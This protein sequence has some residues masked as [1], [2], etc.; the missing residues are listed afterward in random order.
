MP[1]TSSAFTARREGRPW[2]GL[3]A[4]TAKEVADH[5]G[6]ARMR[7]LAGLILLTA[8]GATGIAIRTLKQTESQDPFLFL[9]LLTSSQDPLPSFL[10]F[11]SFFVPIAAIALGFDAINSEVSRRTLPRLVAQPI[12]RDAV[13]LGK[14]LAGMLTLTLT[15]LALWL[16]VTGLGLLLL[17][18]PPSAAEVLR[19]LAFMVVTLAY[20]GVWL[21]LAILFSVLFRQPA[22]SALAT[23]A[24]WLVLALLW[25]VLIGV[26]AE[27]FRPEAAGFAMPGADAAG[28]L[29]LGLSRLS[30]N[31]LYAEAALALLN[32]A[33][34]ALGPVLMSQLEGAV[35]GAPL[36]FVQSLVLAWPEITGLVAAMILVL[37]GGYVAFQRQEIRS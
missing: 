1:A 33:T 27:T 5:F 16:L 15:L 11:L 20:G 26:G 23:L 7:F 31:T 24:V 8:L 30:P 12:Y 4:I 2:T 36:P 22:T 35:I 29:Q 34:R 13:L 28:A 37:T 9:R 32:P 25:P 17:G 21:A 14:F 3:A 6:S 10:S 19:G 18:V